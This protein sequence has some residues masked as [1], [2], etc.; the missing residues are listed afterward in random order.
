M[1]PESLLDETTARTLD[2]LLRYAASN[3][4]S[5]FS[6]LKELRTGQNNRLVR[7][8]LEDHDDDPLPDLVSIAELSKR[9]NSTPPE[10]I[11][12]TGSPP[13]LSII[14]APVPRGLQNETHNPAALRQEAT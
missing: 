4:R 5:Y 8:A 7:R 11:W 14:N 10:L 6:A 12:P 9:T 2:R 13:R 3:Q 1:G